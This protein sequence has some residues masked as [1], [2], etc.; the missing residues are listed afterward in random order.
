MG[1][2]N[3]P[4][5]LGSYETVKRLYEATKP[6]TKEG[7]VELRPIERRHWYGGRIVKRG[8]EY[9]VTNN[10]QTTYTTYPYR[11]TAP[12]GEQLLRMEKQLVYSPDGTLTVYCPAHLPQNG[13]GLRGAW[14]QGEFAFMDKHL[15]AELTLVRYD[16]KVYVQVE[17]NGTFT[18]FVVPKAAEGIQ[19]KRVKGTWTCLN[20]VQ[21]VKRLIDRKAVTQWFK[22]EG[23]TLI[24]GIKAYYDVVDGVQMEAARKLLNVWRV[25]L[26]TYR[27]AAVTS[28][29]T[30]ACIIKYAHLRDSYYHSKYQNEDIEKQIHDTVRGIAPYLGNCFTERV[31]PV[32]AVARTSQHAP[33]QP[34]F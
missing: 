5:R 21:E 9:V 34:E 1:Q 32:G 26:D 19:F 23:Q 31:M 29:H 25:S 6:L 3:Q 8:D 15:P 12:T 24:E 14:G 20:P 18:Q 28:P 30:L 13:S 2:L 10:W 33:I 4:Q 17:D 11:G 22:T 27:E 7:H 16:R